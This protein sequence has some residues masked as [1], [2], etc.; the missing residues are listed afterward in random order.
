MTLL[1]ALKLSLTSLR[2]NKKRAFITML[3]I[4]IGVGSVIV[5]MSVG[6]GA[7]SLIINE[8]NSFGSNLVGVLPG[9]SDEKGPPASVF[10]ITITTLKLKELDDILKIPH[11]VAG[12]AYVRGTETMS[13]GNLK[14]DSTYI[15][16]NAEL[17]AVESGTVEFGRF[18]TAD[19]VKG[20]GRVVVLGYTVKQELFD[21]DDALG[22]EIKIKRENFKVIGVMEKLGTQA[23][24][25]KDDLVYIPITTAQKIML[26]INH[27]SL[28][29]AKV[30]SA[31]NM[32]FVTEEI[33]KTIRANHGINN[34]IND[35]FSVRSLD[36]ALD[37]VSNITSAIKFFLAGIA[38]ISLLVG[39]IGIMNIML[40]N[41]T[42]RTREIGLRKAVGATRRHILNQFL[43]EAVALTLIGGLLGLLGGIIFSLLIAT[44]AKIAGYNWDFV[45]SIWSI[46]LGLVVSASVGIIFGSYP[47]LRAARLDPVEALRAE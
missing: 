17:L 26:G 30:D 32:A 24:E 9:A 20:L 15:G 7:Q 47:A 46:I 12:T 5:I 39:G 29:R 4:I 27:V 18:F 42:E 40:M 19:E 6:A 37:M 23:F 28:L 41:V 43:T 25:N 44:G 22:E 36:Q 1:S 16:V 38:A 10:G 31:D 14:T 2:A 11:V 13:H 33:K 8:I 21:N 34:P 3:G 45:I 35:D